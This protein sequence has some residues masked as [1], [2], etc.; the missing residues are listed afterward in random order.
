MVSVST[1]Y[2]EAGGHETFRRITARFYEEVAADEILRP[3]YPEE[4]L[5]PAERRLRMFLEQYWGGPHTYSEERGHPRLRMRHVP[6]KIGP[7][8]RDAWLRC[9]NIAIESIESDVLDDEHRRA[10]TD[11]VTMAA[12]TLVNSPF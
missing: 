4:D 6:Y 10:L 8:E 12:D 3:M 5:G 1:F 11:Y 7:I 2:E 9:M